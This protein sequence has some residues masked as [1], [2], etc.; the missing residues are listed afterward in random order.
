V[1]NPD[2]TILP[3]SYLRKGNKNG[4]EN[5]RKSLLKVQCISAPFPKITI[6][7]HAVQ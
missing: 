1:K 4:T 3:T 2:L 6:M 5:L 7:H